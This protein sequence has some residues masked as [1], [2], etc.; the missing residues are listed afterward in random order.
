MATPDAKR[1]SHTTLRLQS[2]S[3][4][5]HNAWNFTFRTGSLHEASSTE[6]IPYTSLKADVFKNA[7]TG[8]LILD[9]VSTVFTFEKRRKVPLERWFKTHTPTIVYPTHVQRKRTITSKRNLNI[10][11]RV[12]R[13]KS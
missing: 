2:G 13:A 7:G 1:S 9:W 10:S 12:D 6:D 4:L 5:G 11:E 8:T 3:S